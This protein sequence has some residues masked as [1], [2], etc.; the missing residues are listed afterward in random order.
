MQFDLPSLLTAARA[1]V[2]DPRASAQR[3]LSLNLSLGTASLAL[4][5]VAILTAILSAL[6]SMLAQSTGNGGEMAALTPMNWAMLQ[7]SGMFLGAA[8]VHVV[9]NWFGGQGT[10][11]GA[12]AV[13]AW[14][15]FIVLI[16]QIVQVA[17]LFI[18]PFFAMPL[19]MIGVALSFWLLV[20]FIAQLHGFSSLIKVLLGILAVGAA[21]IVLIS[22]LLAGLL[23]AMGV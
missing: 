3:V 19:A 11:A 13:L 4:L 5:L 23:A 8:A 1:S 14:A 22:V 9:G 21:L 12:L 2:E 10:L 20:G 15:Q 17:A 16:V 18:A 7:I 6:V